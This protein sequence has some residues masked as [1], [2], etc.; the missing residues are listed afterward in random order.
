MNINMLKIGASV[1]KTPM[2]VFN[3]D[4]MN[5]TVR[6]FRKIIWKNAVYV[7]Q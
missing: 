7:M 5:E 3:I 1:Y 2:Y 6:S 4:E